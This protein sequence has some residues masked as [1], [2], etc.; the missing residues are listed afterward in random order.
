MSDKPKSKPKR[1]K[2][3]DQ[4]ESKPLKPSKSASEIEDEEEKNAKLNE[5]TIKVDQVK[6]ILKGNLEMAIT[7]GNQLNEI[8]TKAE[9][10]MNDA[11]KFNS[12]ATSLKRMFCRRHARNIAIISVIV[13]IILILIIWMASTSK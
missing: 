11:D 4:S 6:D 10:V 2:K 9:S 3:P 12:S 1:A 7:R 5:V 13:I 8:D